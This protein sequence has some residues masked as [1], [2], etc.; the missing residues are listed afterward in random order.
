MGFKRKPPI[1]DEVLFLYS[2]WQSVA[3]SYFFKGET[4]DEMEKIPLG[5][6]SVLCGAIFV[7]AHF[8]LLSDFSKKV[9]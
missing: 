6:I 5:A 7:G 4:F 1:T 9:R 8:T 3:H 2:A